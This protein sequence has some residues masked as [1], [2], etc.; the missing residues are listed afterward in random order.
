QQVR[1]FQKA[2]N[3]FSETIRR[4]ANATNVLAQLYYQRGQNY[5]RLGENDKAEADFRTVPEY[6]PGDA[7]GYNNLAW[8]YVTGP[9]NFHSPEKALPLA[10]KAVE[11]GKT[12]YAQLNTLGVVYYRLGQLTN[13][14][15]TLETGIK[16][17]SEGGSAYD[18]FS[19]AMSY[20]RLGDP[21][22]AQEYFAK[23]TNWVAAQINA[24]PNDKAEL[25]AFRAEAEDVL[26]KPKAR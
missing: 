26:S 9:T 15:A 18:F 12:N 6:A 5:L 13:A 25:D 21:A 23:A 22:R 16:A 11:L 1:Q 17:D 8:F 4:A 3:D 20:Q 24:S 10:L 2:A 7:M 19:L 14:I